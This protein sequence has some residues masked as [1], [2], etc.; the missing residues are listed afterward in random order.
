MGSVTADGN[1]HIS[2]MSYDASGNALGDGT[3]TYTWDGESQMKTGGWPRLLISLASP[4]QRVPRPSRTLRRAGVGNA[5]A[6]GLIIPALFGMTN[7]STGS[8][9]AHPCK[10]RKDGAPSVGLMHT[11]TAKGGPPAA[12]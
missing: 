11:E 4:A 3:H 12:E 2:A 9:V 6:I 10:K 1:N 5:C 8:T 7:R